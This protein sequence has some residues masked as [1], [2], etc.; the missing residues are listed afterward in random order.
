M[1]ELGFPGGWNGKESFCNVG[2]LGSISSLERSP[3]R[4]HGNLLQYSCLENPHGQRNLAGYSPWGAKELNRTERLSTH[5]SLCSYGYGCG[6]TVIKY[7]IF[8]KFNAVKYAK[9]QS[10]SRLWSETVGRSVLADSL[11]RHELQPTR[12][13]C[14]WN[15]SGKNTREVSFVFSRGSSWPRDWTQVSFIAGRFF[16]VWATREALQNVPF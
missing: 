2:E 15:S 5:L 3:G 13:L 11:W 4:G 8:K 16:T 7:L 1:G 14:P 9:V 10:L 12:F 6:Y